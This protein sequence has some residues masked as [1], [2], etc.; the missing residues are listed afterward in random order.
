MVI[1]STDALKKLFVRLSKKL[2]MPTLCPN[3][4]LK[5]D[6][7]AKINSLDLIANILS[8]DSKLSDFYTYPEFRIDETNG[9]KYESLKKL[10]KKQFYLNKI[11]IIGDRQSGKTSFAKKLFGDIY[12]NDFQPVLLEKKDINSQNIDKAVR[13]KYIDTYTTTHKNEKKNIVLIVDDFHKIPQRFQIAIKKTEGYAGV[14]L[15]IDDIYDITSRDFAF[16]RFTI[17]PLKPTLRNELIGKIID[18]QPDSKSLTKNDRW[19][20]IDESSNLINVS[21]GLDRGYINGIMPAFPLYILIILGAHTNS[22]SR[23]DS[24]M[25]SYGH[26]YQLL[27]GLA[28]QSCGINNDRIESYMNFLSYFSMYLFRNKT[29][30]VTTKEFEQFLKEYQAD[31]TIFDLDQYINQ[32]RETGIIRKNNSSNYGFC[33]EYLY[34]FFL[35]KFLSEHFDEYI[36]EISCIISNL[37]IEE[38]GHISIFLAHHSKDYRLIQMLDSRLECT[39]S[40]FKEA[41]LNS[42]ELGDFDKQVRELSDNI[43][44]KIGNHSEERRSRLERQDKF[45]ASSYQ[46]IEEVHKDAKKEESRQN[47]VRCA[48]QTVEVIGVILKNRYGSI[49]NKDFD[50]ILKNTVDANL[51][52]LT[53]FIKI[54]SNQEFISLLENFISNEITSENVDSVKLKKEIHGMLVSMNFATIYA[55]ILKTISSIGSEYISRYFSKLSN[56]S[57]ANPSYILIKRGLEMQYKKQFAEDD[58][59]K[60]INDTEMSHLARTILNLLVVNHIS[61]HY[62][63]FKEKSRIEKK[64][65]FR[66]NTILKRE[67]QIKSLESR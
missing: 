49:K 14:V 56:N 23:L 44:F 18:S 53:S 12:N 47:E 1:D 50:K 63:N 58:I 60:E 8:A 26:C 28:F 36:E 64:F 5:P 4:S 34:Y 30:L 40:T 61:T 42:E 32:L 15:I 59:L 31:Y 22:S 19:K 45:E 46:E 16:S 65:G 29:F 51:R 48:I 38:N 2:S 55:I 9:L 41:K 57:T 27:I 39:F 6:V 37:D 54:V 10:I 11:Y 24:P 20:K 35:G 67:Q 33:Y 7:M 62:F 52:L 13:N 3:D 25:S 66:P 21:L 17:M 43:E